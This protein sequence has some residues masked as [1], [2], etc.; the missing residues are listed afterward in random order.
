M[1]KTVH[2][3]WLTLIIIIAGGFY[4]WPG[5]DAPSKPTNTQSSPEAARSAYSNNQ[6]VIGSA[7][8]SQQGSRRGFIPPTGYRDNRGQSNFSAPAD[9]QYRQPQY[10]LPSVPY[11]PSQDQATQ[12]GY[13]YG[14]HSLEQIRT[15]PVYQYRQADNQPHTLNRYPGQPFENYPQQRVFEPPSFFQGSQGFQQQSD[16]TPPSLGWQQPSGFP[17]RPAD[18]GYS[19]NQ[20]NPSYQSHMLKPRNPGYIFRP[21]EKKRSGPKRW[22]GNYRRNPRTRHYSPPPAENPYFPEQNP[23]PWRQPDQVYNNN[24]L[25]AG[26]GLPLRQW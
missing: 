20:F 11:G 13:L 5:D 8:G 23:S 15:A 12:P 22:T 17:V 1:N 9:Y 26:T 6:P 10:S 3:I 24:S 4:L 19:R 21:L 25:W 16:V 2:R 14:Q 7:P 18:D